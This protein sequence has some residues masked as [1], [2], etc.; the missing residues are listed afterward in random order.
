MATGFRGRDGARLACTSPGVEL[1]YEDGDRVA[2]YPEAPG[3][4]EE[5]R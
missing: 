1:G 4:H 2:N 3:F 5:S